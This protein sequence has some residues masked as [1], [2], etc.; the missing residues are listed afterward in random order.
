MCLLKGCIKRT[1]I[2]PI[3]DK[4]E[5]M[6]LA[7]LTWPEVKEYLEGRKDIVIPL[8]SVEEHGYHLPLSTD[9]DIALALAKKISD[10]TGVVM[11]PLIHYGVCNTTRAY[12]GT[13]AITFDTMRSLLVDVLSSLKDSGFERIYFISGHLGSSHVSALKEASRNSGL[14]VFFLDH[15]RLDISDILETEAFHACEA[16]TSL[17][18][19]LHPE[20]VDMDK[21]VD[22][23]IEHLAYDV[24]GIKKTESGVWGYPTKATA[25]KGKRI[26]DRFIDDFTSFIKSNK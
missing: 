5:G 25:E 20:N 14:E 3:P 19:H 1:L 13:V 7:A 11:A 23:E 12:P 4:L 21:A 6:D 8:G 24:K 16:E 15:R 18:L 2:Y 10:R 9:G 17:M 22:E 26:F